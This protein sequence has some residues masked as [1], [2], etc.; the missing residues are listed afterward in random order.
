M[1]LTVVNVCIYMYI[2][3]RKNHTRSKYK[4]QCLQ[5][6]KNPLSPET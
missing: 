5:K 3:M 4:E 6:A 2:C 1:K